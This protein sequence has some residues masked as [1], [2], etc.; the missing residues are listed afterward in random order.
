MPKSRSVRKVVRRRAA[1]ATHREQ[2]LRQQRNTLLRFISYL[3]TQQRTT[4]QAA[5]VAP[6]TTPPLTITRIPEDAEEA[7][8]LNADR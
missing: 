6:A 2:K 5:T 1:L 8:A 3:K 4:T 7:V